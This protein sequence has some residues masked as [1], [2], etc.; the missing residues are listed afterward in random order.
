M[1]LGILQLYARGKRGLESLHLQVLAETDLVYYTVLS[2]RYTSPTNL[3]S[4][5]SNAY[6]FTSTLVKPGDLVLLFTGPG[7]PTSKVEAKTGRK[8]HFRYWSLPTPIWSDPST[9]AVLLEVAGWRATKYEG[10]PASPIANVQGNAVE[11]QKAP[12]MTFV[13]KPPLARYLPIIFPDARS[14]VKS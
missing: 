7:K 10:D 2:T 8:T 11:G 13:S 6:W 3:L 4:P 14:T 1:R 9:C 12:S 5:P